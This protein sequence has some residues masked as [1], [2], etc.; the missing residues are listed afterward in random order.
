VVNIE[1]VQP[2]RDRK[3]I[4]AMKKVLL[5]DLIYGTRNHLLLI[6][7]INSGLRIS[8]LLTL[9]IGDTVIQKGKIR[10]SIERREKKTG[11]YRQ[12][13]LNASVQKAIKL[14]LDK[15]GAYSLEQPLFASRKGNGPINRIQAYKILNTAARQVGIQDRIGTHTLRKTFGYH[16]FKQGIGI[17]Y[18]QAALNHKTPSETRRYIGIIQDDIDNFINILNL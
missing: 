4:E 3:K 5:G 14:H 16:A 2:I 8:D 11:K 18:I 7:G 9:R 1:V 17:E 6:L 12:F 13:I 15:L 10:D